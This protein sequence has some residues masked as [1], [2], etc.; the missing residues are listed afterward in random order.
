MDKDKRNGPESQAGLRWPQGAKNPLEENFNNRNQTNSN[1]TRHSENLTPTTALTPAQGVSQRENPLLPATTQAGLNRTR[2]KWTEEINLYIMRLYYTITNLETDCT[3]Y[4]QELHTRFT[5]KYPTITVTAQRIADQRRAIV[6]RNLIPAAILKQIKEEVRQILHAD[7]RDTENG[8]EDQQTEEQTANQPPVE[9]ITSA[10]EN[11]TTNEDIRMINQIKEVFQQSVA[12][13]SGLNP[14]KRPSIPRQNSSKR[15]GKIVSILNSNILPEILPN[16]T[17]FEDIH[18]AIYCAALSAAQCNGSK[19]S[20][21][22]NQT[23]QKPSVPAWQRRLQKKIESTRRDLGRLLEYS[24]GRPSKRLTRLTAEIFKKYRIHSSQ[25]KNSTV[26]EFID[27]LKQKLACFAGRLRRYVK[28]KQRKE[29][30]GLFQRNEKSFYRNLKNNT[31]FERDLNSREDEKFPTRENITEFWSSLWSKPAT[32]NE[33]AKWIEDEKCDM[34]KCVQMETSEITLETLRETIQNTHNW[35]APGSDGIHNYWYKKLTCAHLYLLQYLNSWLENPTLMPI[36][37][38]QG[39]TYLIPKG[40]DTINPSQYRPITCLQT[41]YK[42][43][44]ACITRLISNH[45]DNNNILAEE[46]KGCR[47]GSKGCKEQ[48][49]TDEIILNQAQKKMRNI[50]M[51]YID[52]KKAFDSVPHSWLIKTLEIYKVNPN[53]RNFLKHIMSNWRTTIHLTAGNMKTE[54]I[55]ISRGIFQGD[56]LSALWF[57]LAINPLSNLLNKTKYGFELKAP[58]GTR[59]KITHQLYMDDLKLYAGTTTQ[60]RHLL[61]IVEMFSKDIHMEFGLDKCKVLNIKKGNIELKGFETEDGESIEP[62]DETDTYKYLGILQSKRIQHTQVKNKLISQFKKRLKTILETKLNTR[63][64]VKAINTFAIPILT[65][66][67]GT[68][69]WNTTDLEQLNRTVRTMMTKH[70]N[71]HKTSSIERITLPTSEGGLGIIDIHNLHNSQIRALRQYFHG[72]KH[73]SQLHAII[74][75]TDIRYTPLNL[76]NNS[77]QENEGIQDI[78][79]K[80]ESWQSKALHGRHAQDLMRADVDKT[81]SNAWLVRGELFPETTGHMIAI[82][83]QVIKTRNYR[84]AVLRDPTTGDDKCRKCNTKIENIQHIT[85]GCTLLAQN[86]YSHRHNQLANIVHQELAVLHNLINETSRMPYYK[87]KPESVM[88]NQNCKLYYDRAIIT[89]RTV[90]HNRPDIVFHNKHTKEVYLIDIAVPNTHNI[91]TTSQEKIR[92]YEE[93]KIEIKRI[94]DAE[95]ISIVPIIISTTGIVPNSLQKNLESIGLKP[96]LY[97]IIQKAV[98][99]NTCH[100][101]RKF[102]GE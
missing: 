49:V 3:S 60:L 75:S 70:R 45:V 26:E 85:G 95:K 2:M 78:T 39:T 67:F 23:K 1:E 63:N 27:T 93:L 52:Y 41:I 8:Q 74:C 59:L 57:C 37:L 36:F 86:D 21:R 33:K 47:K 61:K 17:T 102:L 12:L 46:Q 53:I 20:A 25:D 35:K 64:I 38:T 29:Q 81:A 54:P 22:N 14:T 15:L 77:V 58:D 11:D 6:T 32:H 82:Q 31:N 48:L 65:Y 88:E 9:E 92:K 87:Y 10:P 16:L 4:R 72:K 40:E 44:T 100:I 62:M 71:H 91:T 51:S 90:H 30:N 55:M 73:G 101:V 34:E 18:T 13:Y 50:F 28:S 42:I 94:W 84:K 66:S 76:A 80:L 24:R 83:D 68:V 79:E 7:T 19:I 96:Y 98:I 89:D 43:L 97:T 5:E 69:H 99:L 56:S